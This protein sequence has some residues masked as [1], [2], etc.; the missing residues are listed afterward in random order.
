MRDIAVHRRGCLGNV[1]SMTGARSD[2]GHNIGKPRAWAFPLLMFFFFLPVA[3]GRH[4]RQGVNP[5]WWSLATPC[6]G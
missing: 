6:F 1:A 4:Q 3:I 5:P 2:L